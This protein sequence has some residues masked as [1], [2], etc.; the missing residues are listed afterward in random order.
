MIMDVYHPGISERKYLNKNP[1]LQLF[2]FGFLP[3]F[4]VH[5]IRKSD[6]ISMEYLVGYLLD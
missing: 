6:Y 1:Y 4:F 3:Y 2:L 5:K